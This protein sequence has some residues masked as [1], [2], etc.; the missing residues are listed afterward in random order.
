MLLLVLT[1]ACTPEAADDTAPLPDPAALVL[2]SLAGMSVVYVHVDTLRADHLPMYGYDRPTTP[3]LAAR[4][5]LQVDG[6]Y[7][8]SSWTVPSTASLLTGQPPE[9]HGANS[10]DAGEDAASAYIEV[11]APGFP[12]HLQS[13]GWATALFAGNVWVAEQ[14]DLWKGFDVH[15][16]IPKDG[17]RYNL[18]AAVDDGLAWIDALPDDQRFLLFFQPLDT[19]TPYWVAPE[20]RGTFATSE[21][22]F[23]LDEPDAEVQAAEIN[24]ALRQDPDGTTEALVDAYDEALL[25][26]DRGMERLL[27]GLTARGLDERVLVVFTADHGE[28]LNDAGDG[29]WGHARWLRE[30]LVRNPMLI[31]GP[32]IE[33]GRVSCVTPNENV[34]PTL[35]EALGVPAMEGTR[36]RSLA[37]GCETLAVSSLYDDRTHMEQINASTGEER[38]T[39]DC[40]TGVETGWDLV[41]DPAQIRE[42]RRS[43]L[44]HGATLRRALDEAVA[45]TLARLPETDCDAKD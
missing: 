29:T 8:S 9:V 17:K 14:S 22:P 44:A 34:F 37:T 31:R 4:E 3:G 35:L 38:L 39:R 42:L 10:R 13:Q 36:G 20:D 33:P 25:G 26:L 6:V 21:P 28:T 12:A 15:E 19:H 18:D 40:A 16:H 24:D 27:A 41:A 11:D 7:G 23:D 32:G 30:E 2:P 43:D 1:A 45:D 5:W